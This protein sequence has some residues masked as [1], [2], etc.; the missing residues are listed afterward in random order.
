MLIHEII[1]NIMVHAFPHQQP[2]IL[3]IALKV[4]DH[5]QHLLQLN[6][7]GI[8]LFHET[9]HHEKTAFAQKLIHI[10]SEQIDGEFSTETGTEGSTYTLIF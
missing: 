8:S 4:L 6:H 5:G 2:G 3:S 9:E 10:L 1:G 7:N